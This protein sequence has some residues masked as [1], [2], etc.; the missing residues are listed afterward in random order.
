MPEM[1]PATIVLLLIILVICVFSGRKM[2]RQWTGKS[3]C[4]GGGGDA[5]RAPKRVKVLD[6][7][8]SHYAHSKDVL[9]GGMMCEECEKHVAN[10]VNAIP[11]TWA[12]VDWATQTAHILSKEPIDDEKLKAAVEEAGYYIVKPR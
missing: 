6:T 7:D 1:S 12:R 5:K 10:A 4:C 3:N 2:Y 9:I 11:G 8:E